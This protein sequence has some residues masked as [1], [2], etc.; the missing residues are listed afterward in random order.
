M[1]YLG[2]CFCK[3]D[4]Y[5]YGSPMFLKDHEYDVFIDIYF[6]EMET[7]WIEDSKKNSHRFYV[8]KIDPSLDWEFY[9]LPFY[10]EFFYTKQ[11]IRKVKLDRL[12]VL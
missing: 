3:K 5:H 9:K 6:S 8:D 12:N 7:Y 1:K 10:Y 11:E 4:F 2:K